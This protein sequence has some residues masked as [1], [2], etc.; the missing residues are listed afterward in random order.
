M[1]VADAPVRT[2]ASVIAR[3]EQISAELP[4]TDGVACFNQMYLTVTKLVDQRISAG[5]FADAPMIEMLDVVFADIY[6]AAVDAAA[7]GAP[8]PKAWVPL[9]SRRADR[10]VEPIQFALAGMNAHINHDLPLAVVTTC[11][12][13]GTAPDAGT[14]HADYLKVNILLGQ[15]DAQVRQSFLSGVARQVD[16]QVSPAADLVG[17]WSIDKARDAAWTA[18]RVLW[19]LRRVRPLRDAYL[20]TLTRGVAMTGSYLLTPVR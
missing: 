19:R 5:F 16:H 17:N 14:V 13:L 12:Q 18:A 7:A 4:P 1:P 8:V 3:L 9:F 15:I 11:T 10:R 20:D 6:F 2:V